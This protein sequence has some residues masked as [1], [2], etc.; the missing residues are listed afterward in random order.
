MKQINFQSLFAFHK[1]IL[2]FYFESDYYVLLLNA[3]E[4]G[5][6]QIVS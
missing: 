2:N 3:N 1:F 4:R 5:S 6:S